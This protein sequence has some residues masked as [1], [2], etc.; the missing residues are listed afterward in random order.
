MQSL[1]SWRPSPLSKRLLM[2]TAIPGQNTVSSSQATALGLRARDDVFRLLV[3]NVRDYAIFL[4]DPEGN[5]ASWNEGAQRIKGY[6]EAEIV[7]RHFSIFYP[8][9]V[10]A[11][12]FP[13]YELKTAAA[14]GRFEDE[15]WRV[16]KDG[17]R[18]W[19]NVVITA[20]RTEDGEL[21]GFA[22]VTRDLTERRNNEERI[23][24]LNTELQ[25]RVDELAQSNRALGEQRSENE[26][27]VYSASHDIRAPLVNLQGFTREMKIACDDLRA[28]LARDDMPED[29]RTRANATFDSGLDVSFKYVEAA[30]QRLNTIIDGLLRLSRAGRVI[31]Q[32]SPV[33]MTPLMR[34]LVESLGLSIAQARARVTIDELPPA[35]GDTAALEQLFGNLITNAIRYL[36]PARPGAI[37]IGALP[38]EGDTQTYFV[39]DNGRGIPQSALPKIFNVFQRF[40]PDIIE[41]EGT[42]LAI[43]QRIV[44]RHNG[45]V[46]VESEEGKGS[47]FYVALPKEPKQS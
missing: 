17:S 37:H 41:G 1:G 33:L 25:T 26:A 32:C 28:L 5:I 4:L 34:R 24:A 14:E 31:Y 8:P 44:R 36:D 46:W 30:V 39:R 15:N 38:S 11:T 19:A 35:W 43:V 12:G 13:E 10:A 2:F 40:H 45:R 20:L 47:T 23:R 3:H 16:R 9:D 42:G 7:G 18:F 27:F 21:L 29:L 22:K 6:T